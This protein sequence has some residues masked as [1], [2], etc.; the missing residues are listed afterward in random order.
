MLE[1]KSSNKSLFLLSLIL[2]WVLIGN[3]NLSYA[4]PQYTPLPSTT[5]IT[6]PSPDLPKDLAGFS[7]TWYGVWDT[8]AK[9][10]LV[11]EKI[12]SSTAIAV[13]SWG[14]YKVE[15]GGW[16]RSVWKIEPGKLEMT[17]EDKKV[18]FSYS[19]SEDG[20]VL[21]GRLIRKGTQTT[22]MYTT[23]ERDIP[24]SLPLTAVS[25]LTPLPL[26]TEVTSPS[27]DL[28]KD[29]AGFSGTWYGV[30]D[31]G[32]K[33]TLVVE[34]IEPPTAI[35]VY[36]WGGVK[37]GDDGWARFEWKIEPGKLE[38]TSENGKI[39][40]SY[41]LSGDG[42]TLEGTLINRGDQTE[43]LYITMRRGMPASPV[44]PA[45]SNP[46]PLPLPLKMIPPLPDLPKEIAGFSGT[47]YGVWDNGRKTTLVVEKIEPPKA[48]AVYSYGE[49]KGEEGGW[50]RWEWKIEPGKLELEST[51]KLKITYI[52]SPD[53]RELE[54]TWKG[55]LTKLHGTMQKQ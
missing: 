13:Y 42:K 52:L 33:H 21:K 46:T 51:D 2:V 43:I 20:K 48:I 25:K 41:F 45:V 15:K 12:E 9:T 44:M 29:I 54:G 47:W 30:W 7:G 26:T 27:P 14:D 55:F 4:A 22:V 34:K 40:G 24:V 5:E 3:V 18:T 36:S 28:P 37:G 17:S 31:N 23:M 1:E 35:A 19:L 6:P 8:G 53:G 50:T 49:N 10:T 11:V 38:M 39:T 32:E 16:V